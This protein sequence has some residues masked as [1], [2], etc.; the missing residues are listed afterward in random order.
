MRILLSNDDGVMAPGLAAL[1]QAAGPLGE[2]IVA[3]PATPQSA[4]GHAITLHEPLP[5]TKVQMTDPPGGEAFSID[6]RPADCVRLAVAKMLPGPADLVLSGI[7]AGA[8]VGINVFYSGTVAAAAEAAMLGIPAVA[9]S[10]ADR[11]T[12]RPQ[13]DAIA[14]ICI[15]VLEQLLSAGLSAG[16]LIN[17]NIPDLSELPGGKPVGICVAPQ[18]T[19]G[20]EDVYHPHE[21]PDGG[22]A[23]RLAD[24]Y[25]FLHEQENSDVVRLAEGFITVTPLHVDMTNHDRLAA[26][27]RRQWRLPPGGDALSCICDP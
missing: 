22:Q 4:A 23:Y 2:T 27:T 14:G 8:N 6:G 21:M 25:S 12:S 5:V 10:F 20:I 9:F 3:A 15:D 17:I 19:A 1:R 24:D 13:L 11:T 16:D 18:S 7:N 26:F